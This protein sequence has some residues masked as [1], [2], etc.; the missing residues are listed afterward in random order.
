MFSLAR[1]DGA[2]YR[3]FEHLEA[4]PSV[5]SVWVLGECPAVAALHEVNRIRT[6]VPQHGLL[7][8]CEIGK[9]Y[10]EIIQG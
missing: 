7:H 8:F 4:L 2:E 10:P 5:K 1:K 6:V 9:H 3:T